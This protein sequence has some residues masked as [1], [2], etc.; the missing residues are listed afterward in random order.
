MLE[1]TDCAS[2]FG[3]KNNTCEF[4]PNDDGE[5]YTQTNVS[6][7]L[8][9]KCQFNS[10]CTCNEDILAKQNAALVEETS[11]QVA[12]ISPPE[13]IQEHQQEQKK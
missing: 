8:V 1:C 11:E 10:Y 5:Y 7:E 6:S 13:K 9:D 4:G 2:C 12:A 3:L